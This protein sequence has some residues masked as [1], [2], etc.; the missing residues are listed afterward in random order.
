MDIIQHRFREYDFWDNG[1]VHRSHLDCAH[2][3][4]PYHYISSE[5]SHTWF[6]KSMHEIVFVGSPSYAQWVS[7]TPRT[8][9]VMTKL[10]AVSGRQEQPGAARSGQGLPGTAWDWQG[11]PPVKNHVKNNARKIVK[12]NVQNNLKTMWIIMWKLLWKTCE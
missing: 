6:L 8:T 4:H 7:L 2:N 3:V 11:P 12:S 10:R 9:Q 5:R 1:G